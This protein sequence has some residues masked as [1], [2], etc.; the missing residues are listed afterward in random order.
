MHS[1]VGRI[2]LPVAPRCNIRCRYCERKV[3]ESY[4]SLRPGVAYR[5]IGP[6]GVV[7]YVRINPYLKIRVLLKISVWIYGYL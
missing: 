7:D 6:S 5:T 2:H 3:G 4:H 1:K